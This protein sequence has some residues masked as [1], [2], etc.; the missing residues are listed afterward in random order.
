MKAAKKSEWQLQTAK[1]RFSEVVNRAIT[2]GAQTIT[3]HGKPV[4]VV[5]SQEEFRKLAPAKEGKFDLLAHLLACPDKTLHKR[6]FRTPGV[7]RDV[8]FS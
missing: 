1:N 8:D 2:D 3:R 5:M 7:P 4:V 6:I